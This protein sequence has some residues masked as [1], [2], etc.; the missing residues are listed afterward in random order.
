MKVRI[1][2]AWCKGCGL[3]VHF[4]PKNI[5]ELIDNECVKVDNDKKLQFITIAS[6][7][8][9]GKCIGCRICESYCPN[10]AIRIEERNDE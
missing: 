1:Y 8:D 9:I 10:F 3:C 7:K 2:Q 4:C 6:V 5:I